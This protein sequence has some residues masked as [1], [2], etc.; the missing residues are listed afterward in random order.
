MINLAN[1]YSLT[2][3][4]RNAKSFVNQ[5]KESKQPLVLTVNG[6]AEVVVQ[7]AEAYQSLLDRL[8]M[9]EA[10]A[11]VLK[12]MEEFEQGEGIPVRDAFERLRQQHG[13]PS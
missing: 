2:E 13:I 12:S 7:D 6:R 4:Q 11:G 10:V 3:F 5:A 1:I 8:E 9:A